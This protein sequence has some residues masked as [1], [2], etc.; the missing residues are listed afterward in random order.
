MSGRPALLGA[1]ELH[2][3]EQVTVLGQPVQGGAD[4]LLDASGRVRLPGNGLTL[5]LPDGGQCIG[6]DL[7]EQLVF[8]GEVPVEDPFSNADALD[9]AGHRG[10]VVA[11][12]GEAPGGVVH[13]VAT[14]LDA[15]G[16]ES[17]CHG[18]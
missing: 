12:G 13:E 17:A 16:G 10:G 6:E 4:A 5:G 3:H 7:G 14:T 15:L 18:A 1:G 9:D 8:G 11:V 2:E